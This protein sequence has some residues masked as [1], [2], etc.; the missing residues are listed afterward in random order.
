MHMHMYIRLN[1]L[2]VKSTIQVFIDLH[3]GSPWFKLSGSRVQFLIYGG[4]RGALGFWSYGQHG[5]CPYSGMQRSARAL[6]G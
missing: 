1:I 2:Y 5:Q 3:W 4:P 6:L